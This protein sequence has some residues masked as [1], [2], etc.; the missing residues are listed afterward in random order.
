MS[1]PHHKQTKLDYFLLST[2]TE[3]DKDVSSVASPIDADSSAT[4]PV[5]A[6]SNSDR[7]STPTK[8][9]D[10][11]PSHAATRVD[12]ANIVKMQLANKLT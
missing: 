2:T 1:K 4:S 11:G 8:T 6:N 9:E 7:G 12:T 5:P 3:R 10:D